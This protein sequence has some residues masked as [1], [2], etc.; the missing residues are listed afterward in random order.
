LIHQSSPRLSWTASASAAHTDV[1]DTHTKTNTY[2]LQGGVNWRYSET[3][4]AALSV[5]ARSSRQTSRVVLGPFYFDQATRTN[6][7]LLSLSID[8]KFE[9]TTVSASFNRSF[10][11]S[12][13][14]N[15]SESDALT[16]SLAHKLTPKTD[17]TVD[18]GRFVRRDVFVGALGGSRL[19]YH[20]ESALHWHVARDWRVSAAYRYA[21]QD[22]GTGYTPAQSNRVTLS[23]AYDWPQYSVS[24]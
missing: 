11:P 6:G 20:F 8:K 1:P 5:G 3:L 18:A 10:T 14:G 15:S 19:Y 7:T 4:T 17:L 16:F 21:R 23:L 13:I 22:L 24:R 2:S 12:S 9:R